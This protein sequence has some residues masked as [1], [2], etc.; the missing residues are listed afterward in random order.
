MKSHQVRPLGPAGQQLGL[1]GGED[2][3]EFLGILGGGC[4]FIYTIYLGLYTH[5][6]LFIYIFIYL[7][8]ILYGLYRPPLVIPK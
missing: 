7:F 5:T 4:L 1:P 6:H 2:S 3:W 8:V